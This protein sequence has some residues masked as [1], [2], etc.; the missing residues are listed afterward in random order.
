MMNQSQLF[1]YEERRGNVA[2]V[3]ADP[4]EFKLISEFRHEKGS[5]PNWAHPVIHNGI[6][7]I[8]HGKELAAYKIGE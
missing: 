6:L 7:Y 3:E 8:R 2:M 1:L 5:G 4:T